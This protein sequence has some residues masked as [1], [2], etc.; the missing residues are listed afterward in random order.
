MAKAVD[1]INNRPGLKRVG[2]YCPACLQLHVFAVE[3]PPGFSE[4]IW[5]FNGDYD[6][7]TFAPSMLVFVPEGGGRGKTHCHSFVRDG[8]IEFCSDSP[9]ALSGQTVDLPDVPGPYGGAKHDG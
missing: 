4:D 1:L 9:H 2:V 5:T 7:P 8:R 3:L 6:K